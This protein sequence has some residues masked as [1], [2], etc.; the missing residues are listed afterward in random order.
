VFD[1][2]AGVTT[3]ASERCIGACPVLL[4]AAGDDHQCV[5]GQRSLQGERFRCW[6][7]H[8]E[9]DCLLR[10]QDDRPL[11]WLRMAVDATAIQKWVLPVPSMK[12]ALLTRAFSLA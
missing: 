1:A 5:V 2:R 11:A 7:V 3:G 6:S 4:I 8:P 12:I 9:V 10:C